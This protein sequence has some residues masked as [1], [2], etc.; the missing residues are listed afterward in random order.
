[1][2]TL[3]EFDQA[4][5]EEMALLPDYVYN[6]LNGGVLGFTGGGGSFRLLGAGASRK[7]KGGEGKQRTN[8]SNLH[9]EISYFF[10]RE[11][12]LFETLRQLSIIMHSSFFC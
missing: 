11:G 7:S 12:C 9:G 1:M 4:V 10:F 2:M 3:D 8:S 5:E 6:E